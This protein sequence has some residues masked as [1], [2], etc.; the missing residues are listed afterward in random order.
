M[1]FEGVEVNVITFT[2]PQIAEPLQRRAPEFQKLTGAKINVIT[3]PFADLYQKILTDFTTGTNSYHVIVF[4]P[5]WMADYVEPGYLEDLTPR[6]EA[7]PALQWEDIAPFFRNFSATYGGKIYTI[8]LDGDF[9]MVYYRTDLL[10]AE[11][12]KP[13]ETWEDYLAIAQ[14]FHGK[15]LNGDGVPDFGSGI[16]K[17]RGA[18]SYWMFWSIAASFLQSQGTQQGAFFDVDTMEPLTNNEA[19]ERALEIYKETGKYGPPDELNWDVG[20][21]R[22]AFVTGRCALTLDWG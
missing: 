22:A 6:I 16:A 3:V 2:G 13:P 14:H 19:F 4:A 18:Q 11:G 10:E 9:Q 7:D 15:D 20:D 5:Q 21:S 12:L 8:P 17:R 1:Q